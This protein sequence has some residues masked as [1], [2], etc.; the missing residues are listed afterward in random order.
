VE[1]HRY[2]VFP[3]REPEIYKAF[4]KAQELFWVD[5]EIDK[6]LVNDHEEWKTLD[7]GIQRL[8]KYVLAFFAVSD[9]IVNE[10]LAG[11]LS[12][13][14]QIREI[15]L[16]YNYQAMIEDVHNVTYSKLIDTYIT[17]PAEKERTFK[18]IENFPSIRK[19]I[20]WV[21]RWLGSKNDLAKL[22][23]DSRYAISKLEAFYKNAKRTAALFSPDDDI[24]DED[25][26]EFFSRF[27]NS[28][29]SL[30]RQVLIN[31]IMEG[32]FFSG[33]FA[34][35][36]WVYHH[37]NKLKGLSKANELISRDEGMHTQFGV[38]LYRD[39]M[40]YKLSEREVHD[41]IAEAVDIE[42]EFISEALPQDLVNMNSRLMTQYIQFVA[43]QLLRSLGYS[44]LYGVSMPESLSFMTKQSISVRIPDFFIDQDVTE[45][46]HHAAGLKPEEQT[47]D[48]SEDF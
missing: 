41:I 20:E 39:K 34:A 7:S 42:A 44:P 22:G 23:E 30:A 26:E 2:T 28:R 4:K 33:S 38:N 47:L 14:V 32:I 1:N 21:H 6:T 9:G 25:L 45:Y 43:D 16:W 18:A 31:T 5:E 40:K 12:E 15:K 48:F 36:F 19:K 3:I 13:R 35:I 11:E 46:G 27:R 24:E 10:T 8:I 29:P 37:Y 17:N